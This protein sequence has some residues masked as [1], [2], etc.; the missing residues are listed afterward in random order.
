MWLASGSIKRKS[1][2]WIKP[3][4]T[5]PMSLRAFVEEPLRAALTG[6]GDR[7]RERLFRMNITLCIHRGVTPAEE[8]HLSQ[9]WKDAPCGLA[10]G[11]VELLRSKG[12]NNVAGAPCKNPSRQS[13]IPGRP[14]LW[15]PMDCGECA[16]CLAREEVWQ[17]RSAGEAAV[18][19]AARGSA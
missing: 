2:G 1:D 17:H 18:A 8:S 10:G 16:P 7:E 5:W 9:E 13:L 3:T 19:A 6:A 12:V 14:D 4:G 15:F 11:P